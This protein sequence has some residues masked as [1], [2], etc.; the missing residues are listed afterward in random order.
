MG[1][2]RDKRFM[3]RIIIAKGGCQEKIL[4]ISDCHITMIGNNNMTG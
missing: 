1:G 2:Q 4:S 3:P